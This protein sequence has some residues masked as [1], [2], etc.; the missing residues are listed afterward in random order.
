MKI[1]FKG[2]KTVTGAEITKLI[3]IYSGDWF[4]KTKIVESVRN[5]SM[6]GKFIPDSI[7][8]S[9]IPGKINIGENT[10]N[11]DLVFNLTEK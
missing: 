6:S 11:V 4:S 2:K 5:L 7:K 10:V 1:A 3:T 8:P 9:I